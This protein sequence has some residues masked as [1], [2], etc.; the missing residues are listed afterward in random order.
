MPREPQG[1]VFKTRTGYGIRW[2]HAGRREQRSGFATRT[3]ARRW[4]AEHV[5][6]RLRRGAPSAELTYD[7]FC[8]VFLERHG[9]TVAAV[10][11][12]TLE[13]R[14]TPSRA[15]F[16][17]WPLRELE[18]A[19]NDVA[20]WRAQLPATARY[21]L[22]SAARQALAAACRWGYTTRNRS[23]LVRLAKWRRSRRGCR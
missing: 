19:A 1:S 11:R 6:P 14:L 4:F 23:Q 15:V 9:T 17:T 3:E 5:A 12:R 10:T 13:E 2:Q 22:T 21:R 8:E 7:G 20:A 16:G 18:H